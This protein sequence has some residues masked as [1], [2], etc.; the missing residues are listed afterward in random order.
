MA[1]FGYSRKIGWA[2]RAVACFLKAFSTVVYQHV[3]PACLKQ[4]FQNAVEIN[5]FHI[6][7]RSF[8]STSAFDS[9]GL[10]SCI[11][12]S[13]LHPANGQSC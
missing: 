6:E 2:D 7:F 12:C 13:R 10:V 4:V 9:E 11:N 3:K 8:D 5:N 1:V